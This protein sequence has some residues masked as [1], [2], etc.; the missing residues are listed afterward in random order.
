ML[1]NGK[2]AEKRWFAF[3]NVRIVFTI[4]FIRVIQGP[5]LLIMTG[6][7]VLDAGRKRYNYLRGR[8]IERCS[9]K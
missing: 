2:N 5:E 9:N 4:N 3:R 7:I 8:M 6:T 1:K